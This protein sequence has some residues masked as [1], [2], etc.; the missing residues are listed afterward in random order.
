MTTLSPGERYLQDFHGRLPGATSLAFA[1]LP[2]H[3][4]SR[5][6]RSSYEVLA[7]IAL[8]SA[9]PKAVLD[10][11]CGDGHLLRLLA[12]S[13]KPLK[14]SGLDMSRGELDVAKSVLPAE[15]VLL[16]A[17]TQ[18]MP[19]DTGSIDIVLSH[20][21]L[22]LMDD[23][24][25]VLAEIRR[26]LTPGGTFA[27]IVGRSFLLGDVGPVFLDIFKSVAKQDSLPTSFGDRRTRTI[28]GLTDLL[29]TDF[30]DLQ[31]EDVD[32]QWQARPEELWESLL[33]TYDID[34]LSHDARR[35]LRDQL[36]PALSE[37]ADDQ[38]VVS[39]GWGLRLVRGRAS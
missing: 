1:T 38:G 37:L 35:R 36:I 18:E 17:R 5:Q 31:F 2:A 15:V 25:Q 26:V 20:M 8:E 27:A 9:T 30:G 28:D 10:V 14:L 29:R 24:E 4:R 13:N 21:A 12:D 32:V 6:Y 3:T 22:M 7:S 23:I 11:G 33:Q 16:N 19:I 34:R 39:T